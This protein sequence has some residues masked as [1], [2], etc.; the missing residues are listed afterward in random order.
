M[1]A[2]SG[3]F[4]VSAFETVA[5]SD[6]HD[7]EDAATAGDFTHESL[8][9]SSA[10]FPRPTR[11]NTR[12][13]NGS[14]KLIA[15]SSSL[16]HEIRVGEGSYNHPKVHRSPRAK[17]SPLQFAPVPMRVLRIALIILVLAPAVHAFHGESYPFG[18][19]DTPQPGM[20]PFA[21]C[22]LL[23]VC[24]DDVKWNGTVVGKCI[25]LGS[26]PAC[27]VAS[28]CGQL[29]RL[30]LGDF[31]PQGPLCWVTPSLPAL[32]LVP[33]QLLQSLCFAFGGA[34]SALHAA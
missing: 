7:S 30:I 19:S 5:G 3:A 10:R 6:V 4:N 33:S 9:T 2:F 29:A 8:S 1:L 32:W 17:T 28:L 21:T 31:S 23:E 27:L 11:L 18:C 13:T 24:R 14:A 26:L 22:K 34:S 12:K 20:K 25:P 16:H 15:F